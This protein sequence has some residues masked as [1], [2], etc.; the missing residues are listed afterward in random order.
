MESGV[1]WSARA[2]IG[3]NSNQLNAIA[4]KNDIRLMAALEF[5]GFGGEVR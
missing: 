3:G 2:T 4:I 1:G 5:S